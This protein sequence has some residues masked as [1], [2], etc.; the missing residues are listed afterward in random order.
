MEVTLHGV[1]TGQMA[2]AAIQVA[3]AGGLAV[4]ILGA[5]IAV[6]ALKRAWKET[7]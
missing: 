6:N 7:S 2:Q 1:P 4:A 5:A 3:V